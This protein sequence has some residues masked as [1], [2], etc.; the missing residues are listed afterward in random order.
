MRLRARSCAGPSIRQAARRGAGAV[1]LAAVLLT[2]LAA[3]LLLTG[4][5][6]PAVASTQGMTGRDQGPAGRL[7]IFR[8]DVHRYP[9]VGLVVTDPAGGQVIRAGDFSVTLN[10][11]T[12]RPAVRQLSPDDL[13]L[14]LAADTTLPA[15]ALRAERAA[16]ARF[17]ADVPG[18][19]RTA[20]VNPA[21]PGLLPP[22]LTSNPVASVAKV[23]ALASGPGASATARLAAALSRFSVGP[24]VRRTVILVLSPGQAI[25]PSIAA[26]FR[27]QL[28]ASGTALYVLDSTA[29][30]APRYQ[31]LAAGSGGLAIAIHG[32]GG[33]GTAFDQIAASL[34]EQ[35]YLQFTDHAPIPGRVM[36][37]VRTPAGTLRGAAALPAANPRPPRP[38]AA[39]MPP[40]GRA[41]WDRPFVWL[42]ALLIF[43]SV[44]YGLAMLVA[45]RREPRRSPAPPMPQRRGPGQLAPGQAGSAGADQDMLFVFLLPCLNEEKVILNSIRRLLA[46]PGGNFIV[47]VIDDGSDDDTVGVVSAVPDGRVSVLSRK[48]PEARQGKGA[49][50]NAAVAHL[51]SSG[52][53]AGRDPENVIVVVVDADGQL[54]PHA[55]AAVTPYFADPTIGA[56]QVGVRINNR[57]R[58]RLARMQDMEFVMYTEIFQR[59]RRHL[60]S[61]GLGGNGQFVRLSALLS[62]KPT[63]WTRS[64]TDDLDMGIRLLA[65][66]WRNDYCAGAAVHQ[67]GVVKVRRLVR[68]RSR[69][70]Q[71][72]LQSW[73]LI[74][75]VL[76]RVP[77]RARA[78]LLYHLTGPAVLLIASLLTA[79]FVLSMANFVL[80]SA[81][82]RSV[83][84][85]WI[86]T[87]YALTVGPALIYGYVYWTKERANG[88]SLMRVVGLAHLYVCYGMIW[89]LAGW[90]AVG[91]TLRG[92]AD[93]AKTDRVAE[94]PVAPPV[95]PARA[96]SPVG[97]TAVATIATATGTAA[98]T[99]T[100]V[101]YVAAVTPA[102]RYAAAV[103]APVSVAALAT[104]EAHMGRAVLA[105]QA[106][107]RRAGPA[108]DAAGE[109]TSAY[110]W[111]GMPVS[112][113]A[114]WEPEDYEV[115][116]GLPP[117]PEGAAVPDR[118][119][120]APSRPGGRQ[121]R[122]RAAVGLAAVLACAAF[123]AVTVGSG[124]LGSHSPGRG[125]WTPVFNGYGAISVAGSGP[126]QAITL[127]P[128]RARTPAVTHAA[129]VVS[130]G[131][132][133]DFVASVQVHTERQLRQGAAGKPH[134]WEVGWVLWHYTNS[135]HFYALT[136]EPTGWVLS[137]QD[138]AYRGGERF[139]ASGTTPAFR[140]GV[141]HTVGI[142]QIGNLITVS[143]D[144]HL[145]VQF[146]DTQRPGLSGAVGFYSEDSVTRFSHWQVTALPAPG[147]GSGPSPAKRG[148]PP[149]G[150]LSP[151]SPPR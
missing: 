94:A 92:Q 32:A 138:P 48:P 69:W 36:V 106:A 131:R 150:T 147:N 74:P 38:L 53:L 76:R 125:Q 124:I 90:W 6:Q 87:T 151:P 85:W 13:E 146:T 86:V 117:A 70:F 24:H 67:Q 148:S 134:P 115:K 140:V 126:Q 100:A 72:H 116:D 141:T 99:A 9:Q 95:V 17:L 44:G 107:A 122:R 2:G 41:P 31:A 4:T 80:L 130:T 143:A 63:P 34:G 65:G 57:D 33:W 83:I 21:G 56:V 102:V 142:V 103:T 25:T 71:G 45:S 29:H 59:G 10:G 18:G 73:K 54:D 14:V 123:A 114:Y 46:M 77:R 118:A 104:S 37:T 50:L 58:S 62:L 39:P 20:V 16:A 11:R 105:E 119:A 75:L 68:Q 111:T 42:A 22:V 98:A 137:K 136:L 55:I 113:D 145:L 28:A 66:G 91:R 49:A 27:Q 79:S 128:G 60:G 3:V 78:D 52:Q 51:T 26:H 149:R 82:G 40:A 23:A 84:G 7:V 12:V 81:S 129:L 5:S 15:A 144:G 19:A 43:L 96:G 139:L 93:W 47:L 108:A 132:Y 8:V 61:V 133:R 127:S 121:R 109:H 135:R 89:Y 88:V 120:P 97:V 112:D 110:D 1:G 30:G 101:R 35:Y 64:L